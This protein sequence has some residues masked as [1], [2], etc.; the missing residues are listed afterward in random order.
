MS[1]TRRRTSA[2]AVL[3]GLALAVGTLAG[4]GTASAAP[5]QE[6]AATDLKPASC[7]GSATNETFNM[8]SDEAPHSF[9]P[10]QTANPKICGDIN[11]KI[12]KWA[13]AN[14]LRAQICFIPT[15]GKPYC[16]KWKNLKKGSTLNKWRV[17][18]TDVIPGTKY[19]IKL[20]GASGVFKGKLAD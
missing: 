4:T 14:P 3:S 16:D 7:Y 11:L 15:N 18:A 9:G 5:A 19:K 6:R 12:T 10:Y 17:L 8:G 20:D 1:T 2:A 13:H